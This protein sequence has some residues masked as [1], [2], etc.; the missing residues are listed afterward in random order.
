LNDSDD[1]FILLQEV[2]ERNIVMGAEI[3]PQLVVLTPGKLG[4]SDER[5]ELQKEFQQSYIQPRQNV[6]EEVFNEILYTDE[7]VL[8]DYNHKD[9]DEGGKE[10]DLSVQENAQ[11]QLKGSVGGV[12]GILSIQTSVSEGT[13]TI[14]S[15]AAIL[16][17]IY[18]ID[19]MTARRMLGEPKKID[20][21][22][23]NN[24]I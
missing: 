17:L 18:G 16:E 2:I 9:E 20:N 23:E 24:N 8:K 15:G 11:A 4:S 7:M 3:P 6:I 12:Q 14:D 5:E 10:E 13:T 22:T 19:P 1:R 21:N